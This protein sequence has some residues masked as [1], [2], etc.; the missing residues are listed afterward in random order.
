MRNKISLDLLNQK[1]ISCEFS[2]DQ[3]IIDK[4]KQSLEKEKNRILIVREI[5]EQIGDQI[6]ELKD[7]GVASYV[8]ADRIE[9]EL[10]R[11]N[12]KDYSMSIYPWDIEDYLEKRKL[13]EINYL[14]K[15]QLNE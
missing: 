8:I 3:E 1:D 11:S 12:N 13:K 6:E 9:E 7:M 2:L 4:L 10:K 15:K 5:L 14:N